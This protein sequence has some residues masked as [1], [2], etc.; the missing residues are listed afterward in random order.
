M[1]EA[2]MLMP[3]GCDG[4]FPQLDVVARQIVE[5][6][7]SRG[8]DLPPDVT[9]EYGELDGCKFVSRVSWPRGRVWVGYGRESKLGQEEA[10]THASLL[11]VA[12]R[13]FT[14]FWPRE[15]RPIRL[16]LEPILSQG[17][18]LTVL[19]GWT[20]R[21]R[22]KRFL[23]GGESF[24]HM[25]YV[26]FCKCKQAWHR[27]DRLLQPCLCRTHHKTYL[28]RKEG[29]LDYPPQRPGEPHQIPTEKAFG[30]AESAMKELLVTLE[31]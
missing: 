19:A 1:E 16:E 17:P 15:I 3:A 12:F 4:L 9:V 10:I 13:R 27:H 30:A 14:D 20:W 5:A 23:D 26:G 2:R 11:Y 18:Q 7:L 22:L 31:N 24:H 29:K 6:V 28:D 21:W 8:D 25:R